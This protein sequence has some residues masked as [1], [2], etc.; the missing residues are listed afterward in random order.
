MNDISKKPLYVGD[1]RRPISR[2][3]FSLRCNSDYSVSVMD[4]PQG[5]RGRYDGFDT[6]VDGLRAILDDARESKVVGPTLY[7]V[8]FRD[9]YT[10]K[11]KLDKT[12]REIIVGIVGEHN[13]QVLISIGMD[14]QG[15]A[16]N[17]TYVKNPQ[18]GNAA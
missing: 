7:D 10:R 9:G 11:L 15:S 1:G 8:V 13:Q 6:L 18:L 14:G 12:Q 4:A 5:D 3:E 2:R 17:V 16:P